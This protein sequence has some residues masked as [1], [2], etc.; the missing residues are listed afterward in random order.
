MLLWSIKARCIQEI[1]YLEESNGNLQA[2]EIKSNPQSK[3]KIP[4]T[5]R[6]AYPDTETSILTQENY[7]DFLLP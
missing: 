3:A 1:D 5:F 2:W 6:K 7:D 4:L